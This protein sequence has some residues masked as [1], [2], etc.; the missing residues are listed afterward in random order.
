MERV[1]IERGLSNGAFI[2]TWSGVSSG[3]APNG[4]GGGGGHVQNIT[5]RNFNISCPTPIVITQC[6]YYATIGD[7]RRCDS[8]TLGISDITWENITATA[9]YQLASI[10][11]SKL[12]PCTLQWRNVNIT[13]SRPD[14]TV[15]C[16][17]IQNQN[18]TGISGPNIPCTAWSNS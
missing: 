9:T 1:T 16:A 17:N 6:T 5:F 13:S 8:S 12:V 14:A 10:H 4:G 3:V 7:Q 2:K 18:I 11:C 15:Q